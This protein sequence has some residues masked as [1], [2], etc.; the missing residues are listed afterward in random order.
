MEWRYARWLKPLDQIQPL[1]DEE[2]MSE[3][4]AEV[5]T[6][7]FKEAEVLVRAE[8]VALGLPADPAFDPEWLAEAEKALAPFQKP[9]C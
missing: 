6:A 2:I 3:K 1:T 7:C 8:N 5:I 9:K 4:G